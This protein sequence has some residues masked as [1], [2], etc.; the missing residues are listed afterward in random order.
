MFF[1]LYN[2]WSNIFIRKCSSSK[3]RV[4]LKHDLVQ[5][6]PD[7]NMWGFW[8]SK[9]NVDHK[10]KC[11][12]ICRRQNN[13]CL[14]FTYLIGYIIS[15]EINVNIIS[16]LIYEQYPVNSDAFI[17]WNIGLESVGSHS[18]FPVNRVINILFLHLKLWWY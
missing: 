4:I 2:G 16:V 9:H 14:C 6:R 5:P 18:V 13:E 3:Y 12:M 8:N 15:N 1:L 17:V 10:K 11:E 7:L